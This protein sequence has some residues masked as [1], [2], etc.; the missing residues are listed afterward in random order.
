MSAL[1]MPHGHC[2]LWTPGILWMEVTANLLIG[3]AYFTIPA[4]LLYFVR[5]RRDVPYPWVFVLFG[6][7]I[8]FCG[9]GHFVDVITIWR[10][11]YWFDAFWDSGTALTSIGTA[12]GLVLVL[13][14]L[15]RAGTIEE[16]VHQET[17]NKLAEQNRALEEANG[18]L[19][20]ANQTLNEQMAEMERAATQLAEREA[21]IRELRQE[22]ERLK[23]QH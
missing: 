11:I 9:T 1:F 15:L 23:G 5:L 8:F 14:A 3:I 2:W 17:I 7:F 10:P 18:R 21:R 12:I 22:N 20:A 19:T 16:Y 13:P 4:I 6:L